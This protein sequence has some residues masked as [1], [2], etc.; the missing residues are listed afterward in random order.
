MQLTEISPA[1]AGT[2]RGPDQIFN[3]VSIDS[4]TI[5]HGELFIALKGPNFDGHNFVKDA[6]QAGAIAAIVDHPI[7]LDIPQIVVADTQQALIDLAR[8]HRQQL[9]LPII[10]VTGSCGKTTTKTLLTNVFSTAGKVLANTKSFNNNIGLP[11]TLL[12]IRSEHDFAVLEMG[13]NHPG[14]ISELTHLAQPDVAIVTMIGSVHL[15]GLGSLQGVAQE[16]GSIFKGLPKNGSAIINADS[17]F[18]NDLQKLAGDHHVITFGIENP[19]TVMA[20]NIKLNSK[21]QPTFDLVIDN[22]SVEVTLQLIGQHNI[23]NALAAAAAG[24]AKGLSL[25]QI[26]RGLSESTA[27]TRRMCELTSKV[28]AIII[29]DSYNAN[30]SSVTAAVQVLANRAGETVLVL[31]DML[32]L[33]DGVD[34]EHF[35]IGQTAREYGI[36]HFYCFGEHCK[37][38]AE[39]FGADA[40]YFANREQLISALQNELNKNMTVLIK[41]SNSMRM[42]L[43]TAALQGE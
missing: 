22:E 2:L 5:Q 20:K 9:N 18:A 15:E 37:H 31:G 32:E 16:K 6:L 17:Q 7:D 14:E 42:D 27:V 4:R 12:Q 40:K 23:M 13:T 33:G 19:A 38:A 39:G 21:T 30:P 10:A 41:G 1:L 8:Y 43:I 24:Y 36:K 34:Q 3:Q 25:K 11:L 26:Q 29:D 28:G 35:A